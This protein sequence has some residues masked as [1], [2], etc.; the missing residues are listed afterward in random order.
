MRPTPSGSPMTAS[1]SEPDPACP[2]LTRKRFGSWAPEMKSIVHGTA[3]TSMRSTSNADTGGHWFFLIAATALVSL[4]A[5]S[6]CASTKNSGSSARDAQTYV[7]VHGSFGG[8]WVYRQLDSVL[9]SYGHE[10]Y[11]PTLTGLGERT[12]LD[13]PDIGLSTHVADV[14]NT[15]LF[16]DLE[17]VVLFGYKYG[18]MVISGVAEQ[19]PE[20][21]RHLVYWEAFVPDDGES[22]MTASRGLPSEERLADWVASARNGFIVP[23]WVDPDQPVPKGVPHPVGTYTETLALRNPK[24]RAIPATYVLIV[25][26]GTDEAED[27]FAPFAA[28]ARAR[29][30]PV[31]VVTAGRMSI[32]TAAE[33]LA[34]FLSDLVAK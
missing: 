2:S 8:G 3:R 29:G 4:L 11:R 23:T 22:L 18:G 16:E 26:D 34:Q 30:W 25:E 24:A 15:I 21:I 7:L 5:L 14:V 31:V 12:H 28:R 13:S 9:S 33:G 1:W 10:V 19:I 6:S 17:D 20:R 32:R 27:D